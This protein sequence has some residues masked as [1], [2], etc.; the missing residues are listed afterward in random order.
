MQNLHFHQCGATVY[1]Q[2]MFINTSILAS[3]GRQ[4]SRLLMEQLRLVKAKYSKCQEVRDNQGEFQAPLFLPHAHPCPG[5]PHLTGTG[6]M[7]SHGGTASLR[8][9]RPPLVYSSRWGLQLW[10]QTTLERWSL[11]EVTFMTLSRERNAR[12]S[13]CT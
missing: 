4:G 13:G 5:S 7:P 8:E 3:K 12:L 11:K 9:P 1:F 10:S 6:F 2:N